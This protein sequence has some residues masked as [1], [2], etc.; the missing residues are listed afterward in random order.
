MAKIVK[1]HQSELTLATLGQLAGGQAEA[2]VNAALRAALRDTE[3]RGGDK[4]P[5]KVTIEIVLEKL[6][7]DALSATV[8]AKTTVPPYQTEPTI[9]SIV[10]GDRGAPAMAFAPNSPGNPNQPDL[11]IDE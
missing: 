11:P 1:G 2:T 3:D 8:R 6:S 7:E 4:K 10:A 5:R 9:G